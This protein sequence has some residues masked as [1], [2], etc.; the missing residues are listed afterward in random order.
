M[1]KFDLFFTL[2]LLPLDY[3]AVFLAFVAA[4]FFRDFLNQAFIMPWEKYLP[5]AAGL[6]TIWIVC[7]FAVR[8]YSLEQKKDS[9]DELLGIILGASAALTLTSFVIFFLKNVE[10]SRFILLFTWALSIVFVLLAHLLTGLFK[11]F[12]N[13]QGRGVKNI[14]L[15]GPPQKLHLI[16]EGFKAEKTLDKKIVGYLGPEK[17]KLAGARFLGH[18]KNLKEVVR[19]YKI[20]EI[21]L[22]E[23]RQVSE[24]ETEEMVV[25]AEQLGITLK[26]VPDLYKATVARVASLNLAGVPL[27]EVK[28]S[29][30]EGWLVVIKRLTDIAIS[31]LA[32][33]FTSP[34]LVLAALAIKI[35]SPGTVI[36]A[37]QRVGRNGKEF[38]L[39][40]FRSMRMIKKDGRWVHAEE[41]EV[42]E[43]LKEQ[44]K[45]Y[46]LEDDPR[47]TRVGIFIRKTSIDEL[48]QFFNVLKGEMSVVGPRAYMEKELERQ[49]QEFPQTKGL[50]R[51][52]LTVKP[53][54]TGIWQVSGRSQIEFQERV[55]MDA[56]YA[57]HA[58][59][60]L[61]LKIILQTAPV[62][63][64]G[65][66]AM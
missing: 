39:F 12:F 23:S 14:L 45:N 53:G 50:V 35:D 55:A 60:W 26:F 51:R 46:K 16:L 15:I 18:I 57:T 52:L 41:D 29:S 6:G 40:K 33:I 1:K 19:D 4:Y 22:V 54:I 44:Q 9:L 20:D 8:V 47:V 62:V 34:I 58:N 13:A 25:T 30:I 59:F 5:L 28:A 3:F 17:E 32:L 36:F 63:L 65:S 61:D 21:I 43:K 37:H 11:A 48:P 66:G 56:Y 7:F 64:R 49:Q 42:I 31:T 10:F 24:L 38:K 27:I 2:I